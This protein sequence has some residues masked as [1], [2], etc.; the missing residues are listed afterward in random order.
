MQAGF[1]IP[2][3]T[4]VRWVRS[5]RRFA[6]Q[7]GHSGTPTD[8]GTKQY[9]ACTTYRGK[10]KD[11]CPAPL[12]EKPIFEDLVLSAVRDRVLTEE[13]VR[14]LARLTNERLAQE[15]P[16]LKAER[17]RLDR[18]LKL[19]EEK[20]ARLQG[21]LASG[22]LDLRHLAEP[23]KDLTQQREALRS[24][25]AEVESRTAGRGR[26]Q[27]RETQVIQLT[28]DLRHLLLR[29]DRRK[30]KAFLPCIVDSVVVGDDGVEIS[31]SFP[32]DGGD[33]KAPNAQ[34]LL[35]WSQRRGWDSNPRG[36]FGP[37][38]FSRPSPSTA[39]TPLRGVGRA[40]GGPP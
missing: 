38:R 19:A 24:A 1:W 9:Y 23:I 36:A 26:R 40:C 8:K 14:E 6:I 27:I 34:D 18:E 31:Y 29:A 15:A 37:Q 35:A 16:A 33:G 4:H 28:R 12:L 7:S 22:E 39:R 21:A 10:G 20:L 5:R 25:M 32:A 3:L 30:T 11:I 2:R 13:N 17:A